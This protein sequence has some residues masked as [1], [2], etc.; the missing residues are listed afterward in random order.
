MG[1][2]C[3]QQVL[4]VG[5]VTWIARRAETG[6]EVA[7][8]FI[9]ER[10]RLDD[11]IAS[12]KDGRFLEQKVSFPLDLTAERREVTQFRLQN[13]GVSN[14]I[15]LVEEHNA[16]AAV[17]FGVSAI[18]SAMASTLVANGFFVK[19]TSSIDESVSYLRRVTQM[20]QAKYMNEAL[21][22][23][24]DEHVDR[25]TFIELKQRLA[26]EHPSRTYHVTLDRYQYLNTKRRLLTLADLFVKF[27]MCVRGVSAE[28][29]QEVAGKYKTPRGFMEAFEAF[30][31]DAA[32][33]EAMLLANAGG[34]P[35]FAVGA[36]RRKKIG[37][38][39][40][41]K[42]CDIWT[43]LEFGDPG[44]PGFGDGRGAGTRSREL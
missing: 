10:K 5:D 35:E 11:L 8:D 21:Y 36:A 31:N 19:R 3:E 42:I 25:S 22:V 32:A 9:L 37:P 14:V 27:L 12:I 28:K 26:G 4:E 2:P 43:S 41:K 44:G 40:S 39:L 20:L 16:Q 15:Y 33:K 34:G 13:S 30:G 29:A 24:P 23:I 1:I 6:E 17:D 18:Y 38:S 7:L